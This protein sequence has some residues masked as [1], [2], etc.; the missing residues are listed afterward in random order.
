M[1]LIKL[2]ERRSS[3]CSQSISY[4]G[5]EQSRDSG[6]TNFQFPADSTSAQIS[7]GTHRWT[8]ERAQLQ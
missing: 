1:A 4:L 6:H 5:R 7:A 8:N 3:D 2:E